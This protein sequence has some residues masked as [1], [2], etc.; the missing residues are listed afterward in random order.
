LCR[1]LWK[2]VR[3]A[4]LN[5]SY[6]IN[7]MSRIEAEVMGSIAAINN[8]RKGLV[9]AAPEILRMA[10]LIKESIAKGG[11]NQGWQKA[12]INWRG[13]GGGGDRG[14]K[15][16]YNTSNNNNNN[17]RYT[18]TVVRSGGAGSSNSSNSG[19]GSNYRTFRG[20][21]TAPS[22]VSAPIAASTTTTSTS[23]SASTTAPVTT[24]A[25]TH[26]LMPPKYVSRFKEADKAVDPVLLI[27]Q[28]KLNRFSS[29]NYED[30]Y[31]FMCQILDSGKTDFL[32]SFMK[33]VFEKATTEEMFCPT[34]VKLLAALS[35]KYKVLA[36]EM[37]I[38]YR[39]Y[40]A[41]FQDVSEAVV[42]TDSKSVIEATS[43]KKYRLGY[44]QFLA[45]LIKYNIL[46]TALF[47]ETIEMIVNNL[48][49][50]AAAPDSTK[51]FEEYAN[52]LMRI[53]KGVQGQTTVL[54]LALKDTLKVKFTP[55]LSVL[56]EKNPALPSLSNRG[57]F[58]IQDLLDGIKGL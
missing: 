57:R 4:D 20:S 2:R 10:A 1:T 39:D 52:C 54:A 29:K 42:A 36:T 33:L 28:D 31:E 17:S 58:T 45:E 6:P 32:K 44:S 35:S 16:D 5:Y 41:I 34:Y 3:L 30:I 21:A 12:P 43:I 26:S 50:V 25:P 14:R 9:S 11:D 27:I 18:N 56:T 37:I 49:K 47:L 48:P 24:T 22:S 13:G 19:M 7:T 8:C 15:P 51:L 53:L 38:R 40:I 23:A 46:D 55:I